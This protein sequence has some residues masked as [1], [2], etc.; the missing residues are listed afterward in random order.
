MEFFPLL[1]STQFTSGVA[2]QKADHS[3]LENVTLRDYDLNNW[4]KQ[5]RLETNAVTNNRGQL[6]HALKKQDSEMESSTHNLRPNSNHQMER[7]WRETMSK[8]IQLIFVS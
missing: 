2:A 4:I 1:Y 3:F 8:E 7:T 5:S 6:V